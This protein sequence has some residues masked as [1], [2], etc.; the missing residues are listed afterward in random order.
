MTYQES[1]SSNPRNRGTATYLD[2]TPT[3]EA[4]A[5]A[6][7]GRSCYTQAQENTRPTPGVASQEDLMPRNEADARALLIEQA[8]GRRMEQ[9]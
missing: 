7:K 8:P 3:C 9:H 4:G 6:L 1:L 2:G 5:F